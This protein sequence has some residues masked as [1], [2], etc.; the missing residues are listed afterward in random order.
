MTAVAA[1]T[2]VIL[3]VDDQDAN[4]AVIEAA[5]FDLDARLILESRASRALEIVAAEPVPLALILVDVQ[6]PEMDGYQLAS[7]LRKLPNARDT[8]ILFVSGDALDASAIEPFAADSIGFIGK[9]VD[10]DVLLNEAE[11]AL[12]RHRQRFSE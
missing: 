9:P 12:L 11:A 10:F 3:A 4:L 5:L 6:M 2:P 7:A 1:Q 8:R